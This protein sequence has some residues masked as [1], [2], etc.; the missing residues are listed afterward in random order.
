MPKDFILAI[1]QGTSNTK[2][3][4]IDRE[5]KIVARASVPMEIA[6]PQP[7]WVEQ[8]PLAIWKAVETVI[9]GCISQVSSDE[10]RS[11]RHFESA[12]DD[13]GV[14]SFERATARTCSDLAMSPHGRLL[15]APSRA[16]LG[17][18]PSRTN[19]PDN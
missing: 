10:T 19:G 8:D 9:E 7:G 18:V 16:R 13:P 12:G 4:V 2:A 15:P 14:G 17:A 3:I 11:D 6:F 5:A 1:D